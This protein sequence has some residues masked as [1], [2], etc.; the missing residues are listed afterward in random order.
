[1]ARAG[2]PIEDSLGFR[3]RI[4]ASKS[5]HSLVLWNG[6]APYFWMPARLPVRLIPLRLFIVAS[7]APAEDHPVIPAEDA[8]RFQ[9]LDKA[10]H[11]LERAS[12]QARQ[13]PVGHRIPV[14]QK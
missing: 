10:S 2:G 5:A 8:S 11:I 14:D 1:M 3:R 6:P 4:G 9:F 12:S 7:H 13:L